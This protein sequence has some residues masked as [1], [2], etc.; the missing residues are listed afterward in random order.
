MN[1]GPLF[2]LLL[3]AAPL[4]AQGS[5][6]L[7]AGVFRPSGRWQG[8]FVQSPPSTPPDGFAAGLFMDFNLHAR[9]LGQLRLGNL[10]TGLGPEAPVSYSAPQPLPPGQMMVGRTRWRTLTFG[11]AWKPHRFED[12]R[13]RR[14]GPR[15]RLGLPALIAGPRR[16]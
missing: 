16:A 11:D 3:A 7:E 15:P 4:A 6:G 8:D 9:H 5:F 13:G 14:P 12:G 10:E 2:S 1:L